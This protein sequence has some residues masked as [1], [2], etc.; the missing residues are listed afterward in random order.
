MI[1]LR[2]IEGFDT[3]ATAQLLGLSAGAT[4]A[5]LHRARQAL[6]DLVEEEMLR[7]QGGAPLRQGKP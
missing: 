6:R 1:L 5:K 2:D 7:R 3:E 4:K